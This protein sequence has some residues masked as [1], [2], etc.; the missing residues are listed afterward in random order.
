MAD[1]VSIG[2]GED[3]VSPDPEQN[4]DAEATAEPAEPANETPPPGPAGRFVTTYVPP[5]PK[6]IFRNRRRLTAQETEEQ[7][8]RRAVRRRRRRTAGL[9]LLGFGVA[10]LVSGGWLAWRTYQAYSHLQAASDQVARLQTEIRDVTAV[11]LT[12][13]DATV[14]QLQSESADAE[15]AV[16]DPLFRAAAHL[17]WL[18][19]NL[20]AIS[21]VTATVQSLAADVVP[22]LVQI[23]QTLRPSALAPKNGIIDLAPVE[24]AS[25]VLQ[26]A[27]AAVEVARLRL[28]AIDRSAVAGPVNNAVLKLWSKL[29]EAS[30]ITGTG[31]RVARLLPPMLGADGP[32][33]YLVAFQN[34]AEVRATGGIFGSF[35]AVRVSQGKITLID[36]GRAGH[37][38][39][40]FDPPIEALSPQA[41]NLYTNRMAMFPAD[42]NLTPDF[43]TAA[44]LFAKMYTQRKGTA[45]DG[46]IATDPVALSYALKGT[47]PIAVGDGVTLTS[48]NIVQTLLSTVYASFPKSSDKLARDDF[49]AK[50]T[51]LAFGK[52]VTGGGN[53]SA[54]F[55][56]LNRAAQERRIL[57]WSAHAAEQ[58]DI[59]QT[60][61]AGR[62]SAS[63]DDPTI[64]VFLNDATMAKLGYYLSPSVHV[65]AG[66]CQSDGRRLLHV[67]VG[68]SYDAPST[69]LP[70]YVLGG[71][72][73]GQHYMVQTNVMVFA[74]VGGGVV[75]A[76]KDNQP[77]GMQRGESRAREV[78]Q[79]PVTLR[80]GTSTTIIFTVVAPLSTDALRKEIAPAL[81]LT[82][83]VN[84]WAAS[85]A[86]YRSCD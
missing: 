74:P 70:V 67:A 27:D 46:V 23:A 61:V 84:P 34:L 47:G 32:R 31:A 53:A 24:A 33:T 21:E 5:P 79:V 49:L 73:I 45:I 25:P 14:R 55:S 13:T 54:V 20:H 10:I 83:G 52:V 58:A 29:D 3:G 40:T 82:P 11:D 50:A 28:G 81:V 85:V 18:G 17:P 62:L 42:V 4:I 26:K 16:S 56:G 71:S 2:S 69:G 43:P 41:A 80:P 19:P 65:T 15:S 76:S 64:G 35:A 8:K 12:A 86:P 30:S 51:T 22:S 57:L 44:A 68:L 78:G 36:R 66:N 7:R 6:P 72:T 38:I 1:D 37:E 48:A 59:G 60:Q 39:G 75:S 63:A 9:V 77:T